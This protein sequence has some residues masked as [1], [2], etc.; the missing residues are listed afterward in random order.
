MQKYHPLL[1]ALHWLMALMILMALAAGGL[2]LANMPPDSPDKVQGLAGHM[3]VG[4][5]IGVLLILRLITR[6]RSTHPPHAETGNDLL[7]RLG[8]WTHW[9]FY[10]LIAGM[11]LTGLTTALSLGLFPIVYGGAADTLP[12][13]LL[14][15]G[16]RV[17]HGIISKLLAALIALHVAAALY[18]QFILKDGLLKRMWFGKRSS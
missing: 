13:E 7:D 1:V 8:R 17:A 12:A 16:P 18:H 2:L 10:L 3:A 15:F 4:M 11:V 5:A 14:A 9:G 6:L